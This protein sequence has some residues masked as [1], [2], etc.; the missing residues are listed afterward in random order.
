[1]SGNEKKTESKDKDLRVLISAIPLMVYVT[2]GKSCSLDLRTLSLLYFLIWGSA[3]VTYF[4]T[5]TG[6]LFA[7]T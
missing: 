7:F 4:V 3:H 1:M 6:G 5:L 2:L